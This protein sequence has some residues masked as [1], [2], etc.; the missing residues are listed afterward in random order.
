MKEFIGKLYRT[1]NTRPA[2]AHDSRTA[3]L[4]NRSITVLPHKVF[5]NLI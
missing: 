1:W 4:Y 3:C 2:F 5:S